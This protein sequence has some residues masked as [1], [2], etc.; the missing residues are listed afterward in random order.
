MN[1]GELMSCGIKVSGSSNI[2]ISNCSF[3]GLDVGIDAEY[4]NNISVSGTNFNDVKT[5]VKLNKVNGFKA[6]NNTDSY[7]S[8]GCFRFSIVS[9][10]VSNILN[11]K[12]IS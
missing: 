3:S 6:T 9:V 2:R 12:R 10:A 11:L 8:N 7:T 5:G 1:Q 4:S